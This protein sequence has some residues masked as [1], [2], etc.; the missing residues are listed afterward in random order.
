MVKKALRKVSSHQF[1]EESA[2]AY[3]S[4]QCDSA[5]T[6][7]D[8]VES[9]RSTISQPETEESWDAIASALIAITYLCENGGS[10]YP[11]QLIAAAKSLYR[12]INSSMIS[13]RSK[14]SG[15]AIELVSALATAL[16]SAFEPLLNLFFPT[17]LVLCTRSNKVFLSRA[18]ACIIVI[19][20]CTQLPGLF[21]HL[22]PALQDKSVSLRLAAVESLLTCLNC[23][24]PPE[25]EMEQRARDIETII[26][27]TARDANPDVRNTSKKIFE[28][29]RVL[30][31]NRVDQ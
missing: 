20:E 9:M 23:F 13:E 19:I 24:N 7:N 28:A 27:A 4:C 25:L 22:I 3:R 26:R 15:S 17:L 5:A 8:E 31:P 14:L 21:A 6:L 12:P 29:Y 11:S 30:L 1:T 2:S 16:E 10:D 18:R